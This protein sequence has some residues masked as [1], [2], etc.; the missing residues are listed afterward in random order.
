MNESWMKTRTFHNRLCMGEMIGRKVV[1]VR[2]T[3]LVV[4][5]SRGDSLWIASTAADQYNAKLKP[6]MSCTTVRNI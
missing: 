5:S 6:C 3:I 2:V 4:V 1:C